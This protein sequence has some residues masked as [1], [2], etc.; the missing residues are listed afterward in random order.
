MKKLMIIV[1]LALMGISLLLSCGSRRTQMG[2]EMDNSATVIEQANV[3]ST[4]SMSTKVDILDVGENVKVTRRIPFKHL[5]MVESSQV[6]GWVYC[7]TL[8]IDE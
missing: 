6:T 2:E 5:C 7:L 8:E 3:Y 4:A 1:L